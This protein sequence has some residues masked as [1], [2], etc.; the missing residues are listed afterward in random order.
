MVS[1]QPA[2]PGRTVRRAALALVGAVGILLATVPASAAP[3]TPTTA[4][5]AA[6]MVASRG[7]DLEA[8]AEQFNEAREV[9]RAQQAAAQTAQ[10]ELERATAVLA[11]A[12][13]SVRGI[14]RSAYTGTGLNSFQALMV[15]GSADEFV[16]RMSTLQ[17]VA[18]HQN[19]LL[20]VAADANAAAAAAQ[21]QV[22]ASVAEAQRQYDAV[23]GQQ[24]DLERQI[25]EYKAIH[26]R[27]SAEE[28]RA[29]AAAAAAAHAERASRAER[30]QPTAPLAAASAPV[31]ADGAA[32][33]VAID[34]AMA[35]R[36]KPYVWAAGGPRAF[37]CSGLTQYAFKA[38]GI[39]L[40]HSSR[41][42]SQM[43]Q[44]VSRSDLRPGDLVFFYSPVSHVGI[45]IGN[46]NMVHAP[47]SGDVVKTAPVDV[48]GG[49]AGARRI[50]A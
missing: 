9:L 14:A 46:G 34:T 8:V 17:M 28:Q 19:E 47:T 31:V 7:H 10:A 48:M 44:A 22:Q 25:A 42:Q 50:V 33:Q 21:A 39:N 45:Y 1:L 20:G 37:D 13:H 4:A 49:Y 24:A 15:S 2:P 41:L 6:E 23:A 16:N 18:G 29:V 5:E 27:L 3:G 12:Q 11:Q 32:A 43:G 35:Q 30:E 26:D 36:G 40:P 38:A